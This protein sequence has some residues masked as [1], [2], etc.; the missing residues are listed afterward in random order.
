T[1]PTGRLRRLRA[2][3][4]F[5]EICRHNLYSCGIEFRQ[6]R[7]HFEDRAISLTWTGQG[8]P[9]YSHQFIELLTRLVYAVLE[10]AIGQDG[11]WR[12]VRYRCALDQDSALLSQRMPDPELVKDIGVMDRDVAHDQI[13]LENQAEHVL[14]NVAG[15]ND[16]AGS[17]TPEA[18]RF[19]RR[20]DQL[21]MDALEVNVF[22]GSVFL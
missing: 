8:R 4:L 2:R 9:N 1:Q 11:E 19:D 17:A 6:R 12:R 21:A 10:V 13:G 16:L 20:A 14:A 18:S 7:Q 3:H 15:V 22:A 5:R